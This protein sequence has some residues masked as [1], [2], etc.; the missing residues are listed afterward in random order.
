MG[1]SAKILDK[2]LPMLEDKSILDLGCGDRKILPRA[3]GVDDASEWSSRPEAVDVSCKIDPARHE[4]APH[5]A[6]LGFPDL[7]DVVFSSHA[8]EH[9]STP[10]EDTIRYWA[11]FVKPGGRLV[12]YLPNEHHYRYDAMNPRARNPA[13]KHYLTPDT[14]LWHLFQIPEIQVERFEDDLGPDRYSFLV[15][16]KKVG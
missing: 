7:Y 4:L 11:S 5:L 10:I 16:G 13:H 9:V 15:V 2:I 6:A 14:F 1:E 8:L 3:V 12:L